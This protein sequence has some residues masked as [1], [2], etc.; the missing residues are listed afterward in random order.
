[1]R[2]LLRMIARKGLVFLLSLLQVSGLTDLFAKLS[3][4]IGINRLQ[5][6]EQRWALV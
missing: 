1:M 2:W 4:I 6:F 5:K 3:E